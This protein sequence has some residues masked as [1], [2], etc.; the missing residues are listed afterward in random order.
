[1]DSISGEH[2]AALDHGWSLAGAQENS[3]NLMTSFI[4]LFVH[5]SFNRTDIFAS[6]YSVSG[7]VLVLGI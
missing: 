1:M 7:I 2:M 5:S 4:H 3:L 6:C